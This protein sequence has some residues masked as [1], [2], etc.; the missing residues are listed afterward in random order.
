M[1]RGRESE[2]ANV[3]CLRGGGRMIKSF[4]PLLASL[5]QNPFQVREKSMER[6]GR[7]RRH[8]TGGDDTKGADADAL[9]V[10]GGRQR[11]SCERDSICDLLDA[12]PPR[13]FFFPS[14]FLPPPSPEIWPPGK[15]CTSCPFQ[16]RKNE[17]EGG[18]SKKKKMWTFSRFGMQPSSRLRQSVHGNSLIL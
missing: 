14:P 17:N 1:R 5:P 3:K 4:L 11:K 18:K 16:S 13:F 8:G 7:R 15:K 10:A 6:T 9:R 12:R 2:R